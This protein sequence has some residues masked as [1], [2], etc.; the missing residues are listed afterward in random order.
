LRSIAFAFVLLLSLAGPVLAQ[1]RDMLGA[2]DHPL[3]PRLPGYFLATYETVDRAAHDVLL[4]GDW[5]ERIEGQV[6]RI[7]Y[8]LREGTRRASAAAIL[9]HHQQAVA[10]NGGRIVTQTASRTVLRLTTRDSDFWCDVVVTG[11]GDIYDVVVV[12]RGGPRN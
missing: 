6:T 9:R 2:H 12:E 10:A 7:S 11:E 8:W 4:P 1:D 3:L 5:T